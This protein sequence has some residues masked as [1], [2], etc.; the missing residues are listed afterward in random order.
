MAATVVRRRL[1]LAPM[2]TERR[3]TRRMSGRAQVGYSQTLGRQCRAQQQNQSENRRG[4]R[5]LH[6]AKDAAENV[7]V[8]LN[9]GHGKG[10]KDSK[11]FVICVI[12]AGSPRAL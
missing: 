8:V 10:R 7:C 9:F 11:K 12:A 3:M 1:S 2:G 5:K 6:G 4:S